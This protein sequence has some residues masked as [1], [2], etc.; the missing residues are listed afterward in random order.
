MGRDVVNCVFDVKLEMFEV[1]VLS[2]YEVVVL[3]G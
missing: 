1:R 2:L 3:E